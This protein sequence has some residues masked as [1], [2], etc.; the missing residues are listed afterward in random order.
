MNVVSCKMTLFAIGIVLAVSQRLSGLTT[1]KTVN[2]TSPNANTTDIQV[3]R[4]VTIC[5]YLYAH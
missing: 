4:E 3:A 2:A 1:L 5:E